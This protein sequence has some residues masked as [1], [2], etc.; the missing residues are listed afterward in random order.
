MH[1]TKEKYEPGPKQKI[2]DTFP[3]RGVLQEEGSPKQ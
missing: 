3:G 1:G 2:E